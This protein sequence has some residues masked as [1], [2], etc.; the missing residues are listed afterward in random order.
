[1]LI[2][3]PPRPACGL[4]FACF[5]PHHIIC[6]PDRHDM[7]SARGPPKPWVDRSE[8]R[9]RAFSSSGLLSRRL[10]PQSDGSL[11]A[12]QVKECKSRIALLDI[13]ALVRDLI[14]HTMYINLESTLKSP[15]S[16]PEANVRVLGKSSYFC[17]ELSIG[18]MAKAV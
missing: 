3:F 11:C 12:P 5:E 8:L 9:L 4:V 10:L 17:E 16:I 13:L 18:A 15:I 1:M 7:S 14:C 2:L 6:S